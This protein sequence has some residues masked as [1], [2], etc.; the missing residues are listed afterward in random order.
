MSRIKRIVK[1][2]FV[3]L[4]SW[5]LIFVITLIA[6]ELTV[7][8][9]LNNSSLLP[10]ALSAPL[11]W[12]YNQ[13]DMKIIQYMPDCARYDQSLSYTLRPGKCRVKNREFDIEY[14]INS[15][16]V[17]DDETSLDSP[18]VIVIGDSHAMGWGVSQDE[19]F[20]SI[21]EKETGRNVLDAAVSS[22]GTVREL[23]ILERIDL[24]NLKY[25]IIQYCANDLS[26]NMSY[27]QHENVLP[28]MSR[29]TYGEWVSNH[30][31]D[32]AYY[33]GK[34]S[35]GLTKLAIEDAAQRLKAALQGR[36]E[37]TGDTPTPVAEEVRYFLNALMHSPV[38]L[39]KTTVVVL[40][41]NGHARNDSDFVDE[42]N[43][44]VASTVSIHHLVKDIVAVDLTSSL[45][46]KEYFVLDG[47]MRAQGHQHIAHALAKLLVQLDLGSIRADR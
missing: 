4:F 15:L 13:M 9:L 1:R 16:G 27:A 17:R 43:K 10:T 34:H 32:R 30:A 44:Q 25:L 45:T 35:I 36:S 5:I 18:E 26:E 40:E 42:L 29:D 39:D 28:I 21:L 22:Y 31:T 41:I 46:S 37:Q 7:T 38:K 12:Y 2:A 47:H 14:D 11:A 8:I 24:K 19:A 23:K 3:W 20:P 6:M 33:F